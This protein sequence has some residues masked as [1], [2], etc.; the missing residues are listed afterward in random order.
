[1]RSLR[2]LQPMKLDNIFFESTGAFTVNPNTHQKSIFCARLHMA[3][4][5]ALYICPER[6]GAAS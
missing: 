4:G 3:A 2:Q 6:P 5:L 1:M